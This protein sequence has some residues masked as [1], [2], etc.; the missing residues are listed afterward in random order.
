M[1]TTLPPPTERPTPTPTP[2]GYDPDSYR[3]TIG[4]HLEE[5]RWRLI[6]ALG[7]FVLAFV[8][9]LIFGQQVTAIFCRP[10]IDVLQSKNLNPQLFYTQLG[11]GF[12]VFIE[13]STI[14]AV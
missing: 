3:M 8:V 5:L 12:L 2:P 6:L 4:E 14:C 11:D 10:L 7:G 9:C 1:T 13:I